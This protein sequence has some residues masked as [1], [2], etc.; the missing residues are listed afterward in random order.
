MGC[1]LLISIHSNQVI[2]GEEH[3]K[4]SRINLIDL[5][6]SERSSVAQTS[7]ERLKVR[8]G[9]RRFSLLKHLSPFFPVQEGASI[10][11]SLHTLGKVISLLSEKSLGKRKKVY[12]PYR[13]ST[14][15][16]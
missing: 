3:V 10:N 5:A 14:L 2:H 11:R 7:G 15:T 1:G 13:D 4:V 8:R 9:C 16:W 6:G 12:I